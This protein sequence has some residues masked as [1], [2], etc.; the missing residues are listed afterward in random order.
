MTLS[1]YLIALIAVT[2]GALAQ[3]SLGF[4]LGMLAAPVLA[5]VDRSLVPGPLLLLGI[6]IT[7]VVAW[8][9]R[10]ELDWR[11][12]RWALVGRV[13]GTAGGVVLVAR[14]GPDGLAIALASIIIV[15]VGLSLVGLSVRPTPAT[16][17]G[18][19]TLS[20]VMGTLTS[21]GG[22]PM[23]LLYQ[24]ELAARLRSTLAGFFL[25]GAVLAA[26]A[27]AIAGRIGPGEVRNGA[28]LLPGLFLGLALS[29]RLRPH[30]DRGWTRPLVL[31]LSTCAAAVLL[32][33]ALS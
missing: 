22:P 8:R 15:A 30:L 26:V 25:F 12:I 14:L 6:T 33:D 13:L 11:G 5:L 16:L 28:V 23:A 4:G 21:I 2:V 27:L 10:G 29:G 20:G 32:V 9:E 18:A 24:R 19:G 1:G 17:L 31:T 7:A 3:G